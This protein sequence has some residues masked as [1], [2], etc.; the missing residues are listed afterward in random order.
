MSRSR[1]LFG[2][3]ALFSMSPAVLAAQAVVI[4]GK[5]TDAGTGAGIPNV[6]V[7]VVGTNAGAFSNDEGQYVIRTAPTGAL[8]LRA[9][10]IGYEE[11]KQ[12]VTVSGGQAVTADFVMRSAPV[13][14]SPVVTTA[15]GATTRREE[16]GH[17]DY[18]FDAA[19]AVETSPI[20]NMTD[21]LTARAPSVQVLNSTTTGGGAR[22]RIRGTSSLSLNNEPIYIIDG[23][24]MTSN[25]NSIDGN[26]FTGGTAPSRT[27]DL[28]PE[29]IETI[30]VVPGP[31]A[32]TLYGTNAANGVIVITTK[33]GRAGKTRF[34]TY[35]EQGRIKDY[36]DY[37]TAY[38]IA[39]NDTG[40]RSTRL[41]TL[42]GVAAGTC[43]ADSTFAFNLFKD[44][45][46][47]PFGTGDR[48]QYGAQVSGGSEAVRFF[49]SGEYEHETGI[50]KIADF[51]LARAASTGLALPDQWLHPS[52][53]Q[54]ISLRGNVSAALTPRADL[55]VQTGF[56]RSTL[57]IPQSDNNAAG[58]LSS[59]L[60]GPGY[61]D[62]V[63]NGI[64]LHG[65]RVF[66]PLEIFEAETYQ[67]I[68]RFIGSANANYR[69]FTWLS[70]N[71]VFGADVTNRND[72][73]LC[74]RNTCANS[75][76]RRLGFKTDNRAWFYTYTANGSATAAFQPYEGLGSKTTTGIQYI[77]SILNGNET[78]ASRLPIAS[79]T[80]GSGAIQSA[81]EFTTISRTI[82]A[83]VEEALSWQERIYLT[84]AVRTDQ[85]SAFGTNYQ[86]VLY[87]KVNG[88]WVIS[89]ESFFPKLSFV[90]SLRLR[91]AYG[92]SGQQPGTNDALRFFGASTVNV[93]RNDQPG[94]QYVALGNAN[95]RPERATE[96]ETG[97]ELKLLDD[98]ISYEGTFYNK[99]S[100]DAL[101]AEVLPGSLGTGST[102]RLSNLGAIKNL[103][104][105]HIVR[106]I[107]WDRDYLRWDVTG[108]YNTLTNKIVSLGPIPFP[109]GGVIQQR[110]GR[111]LNAYYGQKILS[112]KDAD[113]N[114]KL[115]VNE[116]VVDPNTTYIGPSQP[117]YEG[118]LNNSVEVLSHMLRANALLDMKGGYVVRNGTE[119]IRCQNRGN[120][121]G[122]ANPN[123]PLREQAR[124]VALINNA[125][126]TS[127]GYNEKV[128]F[129]RLRELSFTFTP[130]AEWSQRF[131]RSD[132]SS[133]TL[134]IRNVHAWTN[135]TGIDPES[136]YGQDDVQNDFQTLPPPTYFTLRLNVGF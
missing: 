120:C 9:I 107:A 116:V 12:S 29:E 82:G 124:A 5:V 97:L 103:G 47:T 51:D 7:S 80:V 4:A 13:N 40:P 26:I 127:A 50:H 89:R 8:M 75:G 132:A 38:S 18:S 19:K 42:A 53:L 17:T 130:K 136:N 16:V 102:T 92:A 61:T 77:N 65:Y 134:G 117:T 79:T 110:V 126:R 28:N 108:T 135:Y 37:P 32:S 95:L 87:P 59:A 22:V 31:S 44:K 68:N 14:L 105:E 35:V 76:T 54:K 81:A 66:T 113:G 72:T 101:I 6:Q 129:T 125:A 78:F 57:L 41:C 25:T 99:L 30:E 1:N 94:V 15:A 86:H 49:T 91:A 48:A 69:P 114:G 10:R 52:Q 109:P 100:R 90:N 121:S 33:R 118:T 83:F 111:P 34:N 36:H 119:R 67:Y 43:A 3:L 64:P 133:L 21:L 11:K 23:V 24:R 128:H 93:D 58:L 71:A 98:R 106:A 20:A 70:G 74:R 115:S 112:Y 55:A 104:F 2:L 39:R 56:I 60:G 45:N 122:V 88:A 62:D 131:L 46:T 73:Q 27:G 96:A 123:A 63:A 84:G 85:N